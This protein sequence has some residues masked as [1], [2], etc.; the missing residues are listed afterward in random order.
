MTSCKSLILFIIF[1]YHVEIAVAYFLSMTTKAPKNVG[2]RA[3][4]TS[5]T[6]RYPQILWLPFFVEKLL[7]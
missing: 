3:L 1:E 2:L 7:L 4:K 5:F 6:Q